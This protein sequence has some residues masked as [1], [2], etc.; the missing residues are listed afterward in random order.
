MAKKRGRRLVKCCSA[1]D[2]YGGCSLGQ[3]LIELE[4]F[5]KLIKSAK[6][7]NNAQGYRYRSFVL[8]KS[9]LQ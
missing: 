3:Y 1:T 5:S 4:I 7:E 6:S 2:I 9:A 8:S